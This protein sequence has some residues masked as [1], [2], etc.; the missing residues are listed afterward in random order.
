VPVYEHPAIL[1]EALETARERLLIISPWIRR[2]VVNDPFLRKLE[3]ACA[4]GVRISLGFGLGD[5]DEG[6]KPGDA[7]ARALLES[8]AASTERFQMKRLGNTHAK[9]LIKDAEFFVITSFNWLSFRGDPS[10]PFRDEWGTLVRDP[11]VIEEYYIEMMK[12][13]A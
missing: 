9:V 7:Q 13:F 2:A 1:E 12:R 10:K 5:V 6:E 11:R 4:R 8:L 3:R